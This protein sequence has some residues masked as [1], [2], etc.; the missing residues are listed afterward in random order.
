MVEGA[1]SL[2]I[3]E[4]LNLDVYD[5]DDKMKALVLRPSCEETVGEWTVQI[6]REEALPWERFAASE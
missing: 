2:F 5:Y 6:G 4:C 3:V 1:L